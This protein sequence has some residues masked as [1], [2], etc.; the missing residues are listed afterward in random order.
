MGLG[1]VVVLAGCGGQATQDVAVAPTVAPLPTTTA[2]A[3]VA[4]SVVAIRNFAF[5]PPVITVPVG[6]TVTWTND[7]IEQHTATAGDKSFDSDA[8]SNGKS[9]SFTFTRAGTYKYGCLIHPE[10]LGQI[11][12]TAK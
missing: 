10:M 6:T 11:I 5:R 12:V 8:V 3:P 2:A 7:D 4:T 9:Y 1:L